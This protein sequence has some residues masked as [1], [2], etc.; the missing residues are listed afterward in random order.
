MFLFV[1]KWEIILLFKTEGLQFGGFTVL[2]EL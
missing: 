1:H 2:L